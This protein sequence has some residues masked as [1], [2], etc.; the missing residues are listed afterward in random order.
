MI[1]AAP[2]TSEPT[3]GKWVEVEAANFAARLAAFALTRRDA[4]NALGPAI[5]AVDGRSGAGKTTLTR[6]LAGSVPNSVTVSADDLMWWE[7]MWQWGYLAIDGI[8]EPLRRGQD[9]HLIPPQWR[10]RGR[11]GSIDVSQDCD[12]LILEGVSASQLP[13]REY[14]DASVWVQSDYDLARRLGLS[15]D[16]AGGDNGGA[17]EAAAFWDEWEASENPFLESD[18]PWVRADAVVLGVADPMTRQGRIKVASERTQK[19]LFG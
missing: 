8:F 4:R 13:F 1:V 19:N 3:T 12:L 2:N 17:E 9:A 7:P 6:V 10:A 15:R 14:L 5:L 18:M 11:S 16:I